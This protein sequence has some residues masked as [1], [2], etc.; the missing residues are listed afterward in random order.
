MKKRVLTGSAILL[1]TTLF[2][3]SRLYTP[4]AF[5][6]FIGVLSVM[7]CIEIARTLERKRMF[8]NIMFIGIISPILYIAIM[9]G[10]IFKRD[11]MYYLSY[12][13]AIT[14]C[15]FVVYYL[16]TI[17]FKSKTSSEK[18]KYGV[19][20]SNSKYALQKSMNS[21]F[22]LVYPA[23][24]FACIFLI[25]HFFDLAFVQSLG[26]GLDEIVIIFF[27]ALLFVVTMMTDTFAMLVGTTFKGPKL[28]PMISP[29][30]TVSGA[31]GGLIFGSLGGILLYYLFKLDGNFVSA[32]TTLG[33]RWTHLLIVSIIASIVGQVGD[34]LASALKRSARVKDYGTIFPGHGGVM[35]RVDG[36]IFNAVVILVSMFILI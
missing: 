35:D 5:D 21:I 27:V 22:V 15:L 6:M 8:T 23:T 18:D 28:C 20:V 24:L 9:I 11:W 10:I 3:I 26:S 33:I 25:N 1:I 29:K 30:K 16:F 19:F 13:I 31:I 34:I 7:A 14:V 36:L 4:Y 32:I 17:I 2:V 12:F